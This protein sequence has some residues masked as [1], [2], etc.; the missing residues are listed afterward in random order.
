MLDIQNCFTNDGS[1]GIT[2]TLT[3]SAQLTDVIDLIQ[4]TTPTT[5]RLGEGKKSP[6]LKILVTT[7]FAGA[8]SGCSFVV[9]TDDTTNVSAGRTTIGT[10][11]MAAAQLTAGLVLQIPLVGVYERYVG[12][13]F[14]V[15]SESASAGA[16]IAWL[17][18]NAEPNVT[19]PDLDNAA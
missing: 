3:A 15:E 18:D 11:I 13:D 1:G 6:I 16:V 12:V 8:A 7:L 2:Q 4:A 9:N 10:G 14:I 17:D 19:T 5:I